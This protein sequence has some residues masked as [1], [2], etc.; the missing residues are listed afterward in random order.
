V[1]IRSIRRLREVNPRW[2]PDWEEM[3]TAGRAGVNWLRIR[4]ND[5]RWFDAPLILGIAQRHLWKAGVKGVYLVTQLCNRYVFSPDADWADYQ[6][7]RLRDDERAFAASDD[8]Y[9]LRDHRMPSD[10]QSATLMID[11]KA[12]QA[13]SDPI[14]PLLS[15]E[16]RARRTIRNPFAAPR[17]S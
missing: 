14:S 7:L 9:H 8:P 5:G 16:V 11:R 3:V 10:P 6:F 2:Y 13:T 1:G 4:F 15:P 17:P 12:Y